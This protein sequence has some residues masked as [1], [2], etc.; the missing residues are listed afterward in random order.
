MSKIVAS[1]PAIL[2]IQYIPGAEQ[3]MKN[4]FE[5]EHYL[6]QL[7]QISGVALD[8][9]KETVRMSPYSIRTLFEHYQET[10][11]FPAEED[12]GA[13]EIEGLRVWYERQE[14]T[15]GI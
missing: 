5:N 10:G 7:S 11:Q 12:G 14:R 4:H 2:A 13:D 9:I 6:V 3:A 1:V 15:K 8:D